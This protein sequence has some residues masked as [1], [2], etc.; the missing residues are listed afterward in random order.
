MGILKK[1]SQTDSST[2]G[3]YPIEARRRNRR[4]T[5]GGSVVYYSVSRDRSL[6]QQHDVHQ[7]NS[8][9][10]PKK[11][12]IVAKRET[13]SHF[14]RTEAPIVTTQGKELHPRGT[15][16]NENTHNSV[17]VHINIHVGIDSSTP[18]RHSQAAHFTSNGARPQATK[19]ATRGGYCGT[20]YHI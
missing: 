7:F 1:S 20:M 6:G 15:G 8:E 12:P 10:I 19:H 2:Q 18:P 9:P 5:H 16:S 17:G 14:N 4:N 13:Q 3:E 11:A